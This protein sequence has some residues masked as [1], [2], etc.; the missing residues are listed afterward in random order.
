MVEKIQPK[1]H[2]R[3]GQNRHRRPNFQK[4]KPPEPKS[5][6]G[7]EHFRGKIFHHQNQNPIKPMPAMKGDVLRVVPLGGCEEVGRNMTVFEYGND[8][9]I[10]DMGIQFPEEDMPGIDYIIPNI[11]YLRGKEK[12]IRAVIFSHG[13]LD[14]IGAAQILLAKL[15]YPPVVGRNFTLAMIKKRMEDYSP[16][17]SKK[18][19]TIL[20]KTV[21]D[22]FTFGKFKVGFFDIEHSIMDAVGVILGTPS[23]NI[24]HPGDWTIST[25]IEKVTYNHLSKIP[26]PRILM[27][28][29]LGATDFRTDPVSDKDMYANLQLLID[30]A[31]GRVI[32]GTFS[33]QIKRVGKLIEYA[34]KI[35]KKVALEGFSMK[36]N[37]EI[38]QSLGYIKVARNT[39]IPIQEVNNLPDEKVVIICTGAQGEGNAALSRIVSDNH[40]FIKLKK[41]DTIIFSSSVIPGNERTVQR[42]KDNLY[43]KCDNVIH[44]NIMDVHVSGHTNAEG[45]KEII[46]QTRPDFFIPVYANHYFLKEAAKRAVEIGFPKERIIVPDNGSVI[47]FQ[48]HQV[49]MFDKKVDTSYVFV[50]GLGIGDVSQVVL[51]DRQVLSEDGM[52]VVI[53]QI[54]RKTGK[55]IG[56]P[57]IISRGFIFMK[58]HKD[59]I[60]ATRQKVRDIATDKDPKTEADPDDIKN[61]LRNGLGQFLF[62]KTERR[63]MILPVIIEV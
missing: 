61:N 33:S 10:L 2:R 28:E 25:G 6:D 21:N 57:D 27:L 31:P 22:R 32:I 56:S 8:I 39:L 52:V 44:T 26:S 48:N 46:R 1:P 42:L 12:N 18:L 55:L 3:G 11:S 51:R 49:K 47:E 58:E 30:K 54:D 9:I 23:G 63:P 4:V 13:H 53:I 45:I 7:F 35:G 24:I 50:D 38:A 43:R 59:L 17:S 34:E 60:E 19:K 41:K 20:I 29:S 14:H 62:Q 36:T 15:G 37:V 16:G 40:R 5:P